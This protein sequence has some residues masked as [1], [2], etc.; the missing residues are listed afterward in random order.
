LRVLVIPED[1]R[2]DQYILK[3][4]VKSILAA[5]GRP[6]A[7]V[8]VVTDPVV[9]GVDEAL[10]WTKLADIIDRYQGMVDLFLL[11]VDRDGD[12]GRRAKLDAIEKRAADMTTKAFLAEHA[13]QEIEAWAIAGQSQLPAAW[14]KIRAEKDS[15]E[16]YFEPLARAR[17]LLD[18]P[19]EGRQTLGLE[20][21][22]NYAR[23]RQLCDEVR[24]LEAR[25]RAIVEGT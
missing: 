23:V 7:R 5:I 1:F 4:I 20:A 10:R 11:I 18:E 3:P 15:K 21:A 25:V 24:D 6:Q 13:W 8:N 12:E 16:R 17:N 14:K 22:R 19:G 9:R 2:K